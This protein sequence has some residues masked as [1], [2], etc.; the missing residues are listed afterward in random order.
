MSL[1]EKLMEDLKDSMKSKDTIKKNTI[2][3]VRAAIKQKEVDERIEV[4]EEAILD[5]I[6]KQ[7]KEK[8]MAIEDF[9]K[10]Q[11]QDLVELTEKEIEI[12]L[13][14][15]PKQLSEE[16]VEEIVIETIKEI[17]ATSMKDIGSIMKAVMPKVKGRTD[18]NIVNKIIKKVFD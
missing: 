13:Q 17:N 18:G 4:S 7:L 3:M 2:T 10:G 5:I 15:L 16:E 1:K 9:K 14:Y 6:S 8:R 12:L 11:R